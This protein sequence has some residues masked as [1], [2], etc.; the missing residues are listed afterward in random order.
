MKFYLGK[1]EG[2]R[3]LYPTQGDAKQEVGKDF[4]A[5]E[6][7]TEKAK[8][9]GFIQK[10]FDANHKLSR[11]EPVDSHIEQ[12]RADTPMDEP[13]QPEPT[14]VTYSDRSISFEDAWADM[15]LAQKAHFVAL[16]WEEVRDY[17]DPSKYVKVEEQPA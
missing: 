2:R 9:M 6:I 4:S 17:L 1:V 7:P 3:V 14:P 13:K 12:V 15:P 5:I 16:A 10:L 8:L 11:S